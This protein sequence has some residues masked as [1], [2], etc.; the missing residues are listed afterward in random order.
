MTS[1]LE[2]ASSLEQELE[3]ARKV[4]LDL[5][6]EAELQLNQVFCLKASMSAK[7]YDLESKDELISKLREEVSGLLWL[8]VSDAI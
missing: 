6:E 1:S 4:A 8:R 7:D 2:K 5:Q 3:L